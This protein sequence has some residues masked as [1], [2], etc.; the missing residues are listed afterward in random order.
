M[1]RCV[2]YMNGCMNSFM[3]GGRIHEQ[4]GR[5]MNMD[6]ISLRAHVC[7]E[8]PKVSST[9]SAHVLSR[10]ALEYAP[11]WKHLHESTL[12]DSSWHPWSRKLRALHT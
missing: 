9:A 12:H 6:G 5:W 1:S 10:V 2:G 7:W 11:L 4:K 3:A 8:I